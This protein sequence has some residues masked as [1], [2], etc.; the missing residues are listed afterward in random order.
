MVFALSSRHECSLE[1]LHKSDWEEE[2]FFYI[3][4]RPVPFNQIL[5]FKLFP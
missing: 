3:E 5:R 2:W 1:I 4:P